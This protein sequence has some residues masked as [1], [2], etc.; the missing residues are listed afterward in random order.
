MRNAH[1]THLPLY[2]FKAGFGKNV[3]I[4][5]RP[6]AGALNPTKTSAHLVDLWD[7][8]LC[9]NNSMDFICQRLQ[10]SVNWL[11]LAPQLPHFPCIWQVLPQG[12]VQGIKFNPN[13]FW[14]VVGVFITTS[15]YISLQYIPWPFIIF[16]F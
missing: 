5:A 6:A 11:I 16:Y 14:W 1:G 13:T 2:K 4:F 12:F 3:K 15:C 9:W 7:Q 8:L 10:W